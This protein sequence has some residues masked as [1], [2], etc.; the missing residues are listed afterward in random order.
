MKKIGVNPVR[1]IVHHVGNLPEK[2]SV[3]LS[4]TGKMRLDFFYT[5]TSAWI[6]L[7]PF[8]YPVIR[9]KL[10]IITGIIQLGFYPF[11]KHLECL[12]LYA[13]IGWV[14]TT[15][16]PGILPSHQLPNIQPAGFSTNQW[17]ERIFWHNKPIFGP[18]II[19][20]F[21]SCCQVCILGMPGSDADFDYVP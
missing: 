5:E 16:F 19:L 13:T 8:T 7:S 2:R 10:I 18:I 17:Y 4:L 3:P 11:F 20:F 15:Y 6:F 12:A 9:S 1:E 21:L 14:G